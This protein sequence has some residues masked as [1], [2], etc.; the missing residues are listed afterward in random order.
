M[1][2]KNKPGSATEYWRTFLD[3]YVANPSP[4][5]WFRGESDNTRTLLPKIGRLNG[6][7]NGD[8]YDDQCINGKPRNLWGRERRLFERFKRRARNGLQ[9]LPQDNL[10]WLALAQHHG[11]PTRLL[12]WTANP[13]IALWFATNKRPAR[14]KEDQ[15]KIS[16]V[17]ALKIRRE[18]LRPLPDEDFEPFEGDAISPSKGPFFVEPPYLHPRMQVQRSRFSFHTA[19]NKPFESTDLKRFDIPEKFWTEIQRKLYYVGVD[20]STIWTDLSGLGETLNWQY[21]NKI[22]IGTVA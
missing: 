15:T 6:E 2:P 10:E 11:V 13:L 18:N 16:V 19:P 1:S 9:T 12:D 22:A 8:W 4:D 20:A 5:L 21:E 3:S 7:E 14:H 17:Y